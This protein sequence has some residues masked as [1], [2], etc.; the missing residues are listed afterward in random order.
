MKHDP[1]ER[2]T[3]S[4]RFDELISVGNRIA[5][6][7]EDMASGKFSLNGPGPNEPPPEPPPSPPE[8]ET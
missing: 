3:D 2:K 1:I 4:E 5:R 7:L 8:P 6:A